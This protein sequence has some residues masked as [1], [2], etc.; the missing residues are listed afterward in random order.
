[1]EVDCLYSV[2]NSKLLFYFGYFVCEK[3]MPQHL[4][5]RGVGPAGRGGGGRGYTGDWGQKTP[6]AGSPDGVECTALRAKHQRV[7]SPCFHSVSGYL[8]FHVC[9]WRSRGSEGDTT[10]ASSFSPKQ[11]WH[12]HF[13]IAMETPGHLHSTHTQ[14][15]IHNANTLCLTLTSTRTT[16]THTHT[17]THI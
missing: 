17:H 5:K 12:P 13:R 16:H 14:T 7:P 1:M 6:T 11:E 8:A 9:R 2:D 10:R 4:S 15:H 3:W